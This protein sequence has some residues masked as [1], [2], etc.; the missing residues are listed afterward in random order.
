MPKTNFTKIK[1]WEIL[2]VDSDEDHPLSTGEIIEK[3]KNQGVECDRRT[4]YEDIRTLNEYGYEVLSEKGQHSNLYC[5]VDRSFDV[6]ELH[7]LMDAVQAA[8]FITEKKTAELTFLY[9]AREL[10]VLKPCGQIIRSRGFLL[11]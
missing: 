11:Q 1:L 6:P 3:L 2:S 10:T 9:T 4:L 8:G 5:V 7:I